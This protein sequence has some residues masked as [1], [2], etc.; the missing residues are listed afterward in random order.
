MSVALDQRIREH[1]VPD[2]RPAGYGWSAR[3]GKGA[4]ALG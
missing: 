2:R 1:V 4:E 3:I